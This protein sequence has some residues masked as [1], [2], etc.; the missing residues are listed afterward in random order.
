MS[1][2]TTLDAP[3]RGALT[4]SSSS[5]VS[6]ST[7]VPGRFD[8]ALNGHGYMIDTAMDL[9][10]FRGMHF[11]RGS[12]PVLRAQAD[13]GNVPAEQSINRD[14]LWR[15]SQETWHHG[16]G[17]VYYDRADSDSARFN[18]SKGVNVWSKWNVTL[19]PDTTQLR[20]SA[21]SN[22]RLTA[23]GTYMYAADGNSLISYDA[24]LTAAT[25][26]GT[27]A[28]TLTW[29]ASDGYNIYAAY[30]TAL[31]TT[32]RGAAAATSYATGFTGGISVVGYVKG[33]L[34]VAAGPSLW[35]V[36]AGG[37]IGAALLTQANSDF[38][39]VGFAEGPG[40]LYAAGYSGNR[41]LIYKTAVL[42]DGTAL[43]VP[44]VAGELPIGETIRSIRGYLGFLVI[45]TDLG[46]RLGSPDGSGN[47]TPG[48]LVRTGS[49]VLNFEPSD[50]FIY[51]S[52]SNYD[53]TSTGL[54]RMD[55]SVFTESLV[56]AYASDL[57][58]TGQGSVTSVSTLT[59]GKRIFAVAG[60]GI[61]TEAS[62]LV[63]SGTLSTGKVT[64][65]V[66]DDKIAMFLDLRHKP[67]VGQISATLVANDTTRVDLG[68]SAVSGSVSSGYA[69]NA[70]QTR[71]EYFEVTYT[72]TQGSST[73]SPTMTR[74][75]LRAYPAPSRSLEYTVPLLIAA[76]VEDRNGQPV[77]MDIAA[78]R[79]FLE[80]LVTSGAPVAYQEGSLAGTVLVE[81]F[82][83]LPLQ[84]AYSNGS[85][86]WEGT[87]VLTLKEQSQ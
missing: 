14:A 77:P 52:L 1:E 12:M 33:R 63:G 25:I 36:T 23:A 15:R 45:G 87:M 65:G 27:P 68:V 75:T 30:G 60:L 43:N 59:S 83:W 42:P 64:Y 22:L 5:G 37:A 4:L 17:Q 21:A 49:P 71:A 70:K 66:A 32:T 19:L 58:V 26:T 47:I 41:S 7:E 81:D 39:W 57:M 9:Q 40:Y 67:L 29:L 80:S 31:Y 79:A 18:T 8:V 78:E 82:D 74:A 20:A 84:R 86:T 24:T 48:P 35:N 62:T 73:S 6:G 53:G 44:S 56:P 11:K 76:T 46:F 51:Y 69:L 34:M 72:L 38:T 54:G 13:T 85:Y 16:A 28:S 61:Y 10:G 50:R 55:L 3:L 2:D